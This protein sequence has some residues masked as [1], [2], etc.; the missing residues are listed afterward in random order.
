MVRR[1]HRKAIGIQT[2]ENQRKATKSNENLTKTD[3]NQRKP[4]KIIEN[5]ARINENGTKNNENQQNQ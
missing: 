4:M 1:C 5:Q 2:N 3:E